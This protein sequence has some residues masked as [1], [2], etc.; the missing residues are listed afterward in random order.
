[1]SRLRG[2]RAGVGSAL[3]GTRCNKGAADAAV[4]LGITLVHVKKK[5]KIALI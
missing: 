2:K 1:M 5:K 4:S 3:E